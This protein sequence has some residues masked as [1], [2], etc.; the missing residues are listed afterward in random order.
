MREEL[1]LALEMRAGPKRFHRLLCACAWACAAATL[2]NWVK[3]RASAISAAWTLGA[4]GGEALQLAQRLSRIA[5]ARG[6][7]ERLERGLGRVADDRLDVVM[8]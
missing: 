7:D 6:V 2:C 3:W 5:A 4:G 8:A 1:G